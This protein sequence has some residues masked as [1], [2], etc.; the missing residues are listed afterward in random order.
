M[1]VPVTV[2]KYSCVDGTGIL[3]LQRGRSTRGVFTPR[4]TKKFLINQTGFVSA[5]EL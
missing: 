3:M 1:P 2:A 5:R 4:L